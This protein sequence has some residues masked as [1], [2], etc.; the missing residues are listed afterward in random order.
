MHVHESHESHLPITHDGSHVT[1]GATEHES[2]LPL[3]T[4]YYNE[5]QKRKAN[6]AGRYRLRRLSLTC[7]KQHKRWVPLC[8]TQPTIAC[9]CSAVDW[10]SHFCAT[11]AALPL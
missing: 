6:V 10:Q 7:L 3:F 11:H 4:L 8:S 2:H 1:P 5:W 9:F